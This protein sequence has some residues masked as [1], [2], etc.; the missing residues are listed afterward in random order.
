MTRL[1]REAPGRSS[2][3]GI[4]LARGPRNRRERPRRGEHFCAALPDAC[5]RFPG[6]CDRQA[7]AYRRWA[8]A[9]VVLGCLAALIGLAALA[10]A[11][12][13]TTSAPSASDTPARR[14]ADLFDP[15][16]APDTTV[17]ADPTPE[18]REERLQRLLWEDAE[19]ASRLVPT[20]TNY[21]AGIRDG[22]V[23][24]IA[25]AVAR[26]CRQH[27]VRPELVLALIEVESHFDPEASSSTSDHGLCQVHCIPE[28]DVQRNVELG[29]SELAMWLRTAR[30]DER[31]ALCRYN[32]G[33]RGER[34]AR[35]RAY[36]DRVL[37]LAG[38][39]E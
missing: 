20:I 21:A 17:D 37:R 12:G 34:I 13:E 27:E 7:S 1:A 35:C 30:G 9:I 14:P 5:A 38:D 18:S 24:D 31:L 19:T 39:G 4:P 28:Y 25:L 32:G 33:G 26:S 11:D 22:L 6:F 2:D 36:A 15:P 16:T 8:L 29:C 23:Y 10:R 3:R